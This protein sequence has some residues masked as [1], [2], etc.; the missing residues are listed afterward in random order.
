[1]KGKRRRQGNFF[2]GG[3]RGEDDISNTDI[4]PQK[5]G[6]RKREITQSRQ[7]RKRKKGKGKETLLR[8]EGGRKRRG[9]KSG[10]WAGGKE[11]SSF[12]L[13]HRGKEKEDRVGKTFILGRG[14]G[15]KKEKI[16]ITLDRVK[17]ER[18]AIGKKKKVGKGVPSFIFLPGGKKGGGKKGKKR[19]GKNEHISE[20][21]GK[22]YRYERCEGK[23]EREGQVA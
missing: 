19:R 16:H 4:P 8:I 21:V 12:Y 10:V 6:K 20:Y 11:N 14:G 5:K 13:C 2:W 18:T 15:K 22:T 7:E 1:M 3:K 9:K 23:R 17:K